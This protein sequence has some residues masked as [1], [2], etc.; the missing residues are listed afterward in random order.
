MLVLFDN[1]RE[2]STYAVYLM[3]P[4]ATIADAAV[5]DYAD[6]SDRGEAYAKAQEQ[7]RKWAAEHKAKIATNW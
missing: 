2:V 3:N 1:D 5:F 4:D 7:A 6:S